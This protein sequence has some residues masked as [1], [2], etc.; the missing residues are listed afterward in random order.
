MRMARRHGRRD[1]S[2]LATDI[3]D[4]QGEPGA[5]LA[6]TQDES[7]LARSSRTRTQPAAS[8]GRPERG[9]R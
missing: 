9:K 1:A 4:V 8:S 6:R 7:A 3:G 2:A 5:S